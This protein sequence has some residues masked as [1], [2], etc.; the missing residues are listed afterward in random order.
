VHPVLIRIG[1]FEI[2]CYGPLIAFGVLLGV[3]V[4]V[5]R[6]R[7]V[8]IAPELI[9]DLTFYSV[10]L[11]FIG[12]RLFY[13]LTDLRG[14]VQMPLSYIFAR[15]GFVFF[16]ALVFAGGFA[17]W[18]LRRHRIDFWQVADVAAPSIALG[19]MFGR[20]GC[21]CSGC[22]F[23]RICPPGWESIGVR[24]PL[25]F[26]PKTGEPSEMFSIAYWAL[27]MRG[28]IGADAT[29]TPPLIPVQLFE[30]G[31]NLLIFV[32][33]VLLWRHRRFRGMIFA[34]YLAAY[35][36]VR[37]TLEFLRGDYGDPALYERL[38]RGQLSQALCVAAIVAA[39]VICYR[40]RGT[41]LEV[42]AAP[43]PE[44]SPPSDKNPT[45]KPKPNRRRRRHQ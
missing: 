19:H 6:G 32:G 7:K 28:D 4:A 25:V 8:G 36:L 23:G 27:R 16:G 13:I 29:H 40:R 20:I 2:A 1:S 14:F 22:C 24:F 31:A 10:I 35:G 30:A 21:F 38:K 42:P 37:F 39:V 43:A 45:S 17:V 41:P 26:N 34:A 33:L 12:S 9:L 5:R 3:L 44:P 18:F 15:E 11:G